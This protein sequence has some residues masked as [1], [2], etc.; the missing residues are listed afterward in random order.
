MFKI[1][2][3]SKKVSFNLTAS[4][5]DKK[6]LHV[7][8]QLIQNNQIQEALEYIKSFKA[9]SR[10]SRL[11]E[12]RY[13]K[14]QLSSDYKKDPLV[15]KGSG[16]YLKKLQSIFDPNLSHKPSQSE[17][18]Q[19]IGVE[20][21]CFIPYRKAMKV[22]DKNNID[23]DI[24]QYYDC[25]GDIC[26]EDDGDCHGEHER[27]PDEYDEPNAF[28]N[29]LAE[30]FK[31]KKIKRVSIKDDGSIR[32]DDDCFQVEFTCLITQKDR[33]SLVQL[34]DM[35]RLLGARV[36]KSCGMHVHLDQR[37]LVDQNTKRVNILKL[38][39]RGRNFRNV[40]QVFAQM[41]PHSRRNN[42]FCQLG[43]NSITS[44]SR[45]YAINMSAFK[46][47]QTIEIRLHSATTDFT[48]IS[49]WIDVLL[50]VQ[51]SEI[52]NRRINTFEDFCFD[53][54]VPEKLIM[55]MESRIAEFQ[56]PETNEVTVAA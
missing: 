32:A 11:H 43:M 4:I 25:N 28:R 3:D 10:P 45:Y 49:N 9:S 2:K 55:Y 52:K 34:C 53:L 14:S 37:D 17:L 39:K 27:D 8:S 41:M 5:K 48:K 22:F 54:D 51:H 29:A 7:L 33:T 42:T 30:L 44:G 56:N 36:N 46:R 19:W 31:M 20:I 6:Q 21:E 26:D 12:V 24:D 35:L 13:F 15:E 50:F 16:F 47:F 1:E 40:I 18:G 38:N 23:V